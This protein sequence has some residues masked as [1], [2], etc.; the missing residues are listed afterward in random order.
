MPGQL[1]TLA[2]GQVLIDCDDAD[3]GHFGVRR[4]VAAF[5]LSLTPSLTVGLLPCSLRSVTLYLTPP[6]APRSS[7]AIH[8]QSNSDVRIGN[9]ASLPDREA[10]FLHL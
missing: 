10:C 3:D 8:N 6:P 5:Y 1:A 4:L 7:R 9:L 2:D